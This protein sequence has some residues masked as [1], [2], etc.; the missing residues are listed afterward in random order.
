MKPAQKKKI[1][2]IEDE[3]AMSSLLKGHI[4]KCGYDVELSQHG[5]EAVV[6][7]RRLKPDLITIDVLMPD[8]DGIA[9]LKSLRSNEET[10]SIPVIFVTI[11]PAEVDKIKSGMGIIDIIQKPFEFNR[12][13]ACLDRIENALDEKK[14]RKI[15]LL[16]DDEQEAL[17]LVRHCLEKR[18]DVFCKTNGSEGVELAKDIIPDILIV[19]ILMPEM[20]GVEVIKEIRECSLTKNI[21]IIVLTASDTDEFRSE[22]CNLGVKRFLSK[23]FSAE[24]LIK[25]INNQLIER[26]CGYEKK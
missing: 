25:E 7:A 9:V 10:R 18:F 12:V 17:G 2:V 5:K 14:N 21:P 8:I 24:D 13:K 19:D 15:I 22:C 6:K 16:I 11:V 4:E 3:T 1:L 26:S 20:N 23:P